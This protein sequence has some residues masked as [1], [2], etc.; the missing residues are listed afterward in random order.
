MIPT[1]NLVAAGCKLKISKV[2][3]LLKKY[4]FNTQITLSRDELKTIDDFVLHQI[5]LSHDSVRKVDYQHM[6]SRLEFVRNPRRVSEAI[7]SLGVVVVNEFLTQELVGE[8]YASIK[9]CLVD[10]NVPMINADQPKKTYGQLAS[11]NEAIRYVRGG[12][13]HGMI[14][15][16]NIDLYPEFPSNISSLNDISRYCGFNDNLVLDNVNAYINRGVVNTRGFHVD[17]FGEKYKAFVYLTDVLELADGPYCYS[18]GSHVPNNSTSINRKLG[19]M[20]GNAYNHPLPVGES[21]VPLFGRAGTLIVSNQ[22]GIHRGIPQSRDGERVVLVLSFHDA[23]KAY[24][25]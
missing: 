2:K 16:F 20:S 17:T 1:M 7:D 24:R 15:I 14:D 23:A 11:F 10:P 6:L 21:I 22:A 4:L 12:F 9:K 5:Y 8:L 3:K 18:L 25:R 19:L 13:D